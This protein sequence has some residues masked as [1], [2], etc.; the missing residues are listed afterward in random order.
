MTLVASGG[1]PE[2]GCHEMVTLP[3]TRLADQ[4]PV[5]FAGHLAESDVIVVPLSHGPLGTA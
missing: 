3:G 1:Q 4:P 2:G 5:I